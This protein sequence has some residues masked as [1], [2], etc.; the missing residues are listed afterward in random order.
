MAAAV[1]ISNPAMAAVA[2]QDDQYDER[3]ASLSPSGTYTHI[4]PPPAPHLL[5]SAITPD[6]SLFQTIHFAPAPTI[7][8][9]KYRLI[10]T[11]LVQH[12]LSLTFDEIKGLPSTT[13]TA[14][15]ECYGPPTLPPDTN[16]WRVG[17]VRWTGVRLSHLLSLAQPTAEA[18]FVWS[19][20]LD[21]GT[22]QGVFSDRYRKDLPMAKAV[23]PEVLVAYQ[24][25][26]ESLSKERGGPVRLVVPGWF[27]TNSTK[28]LCRLE[29]REERAQ[30]EFTGRGGFYS[31]EVPDG[32]EGRTGDE[33]RW[34]G[35]VLWQ[36]EED[37]VAM[38]PVWRIEVNSM[39]VRP[40]PDEVFVVET[41][42]M[43]MEVEVEGWAWSD[44]GV[45][46]VEVSDSETTTWR[47]AE[48]EERK[49]Y[50]WQKFRRKVRVSRGDREVTARAICT[51]G[52][53]QPLKGRRNHVHRVRFRVI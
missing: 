33:T 9:T 14:F 22:F 37:G 49:G 25:N 31:E 34:D 39:I 36:R 21:K 13:I 26:G 43:S 30:G 17:C 18:K 40:R 16:R 5:S 8:L 15:H 28:W 52:M 6:E 50:A 51:S 44:A 10:I 48:V 24:M 45:A 38:R 42:E 23:S 41:G 27:G 11:G 4:R 7:N 2:D 1:A 3:S 47:D 35:N 20:G 32:E 12:P 29:V 46:V 19:D 53:K